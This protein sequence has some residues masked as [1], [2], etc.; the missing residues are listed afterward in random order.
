MV[1]QRA[2]VFG[3]RHL[4]VV[5]HHQHIRVDVAGVVHRFERHTGGDGAIADHTHRAAAF[6]F[7]LRCHRHAETGADRGRRV[8]D[9]Q[10]V[11]FAFGAPREGMQAVLLPNGG[12]PVAAA[13]QNFVRVGTVADVPPVIERRVVDEMQRHRQFDGTQP[14]GKVAAGATDAVQQVLPQLIAQLRQALFGQ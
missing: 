10:H 4:I 2:D 8:A 1:V 7:T 6:A 3:D 12:D 11:V 13:G 9:R 14:G 5:Q